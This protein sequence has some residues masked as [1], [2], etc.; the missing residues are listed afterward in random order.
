M[1]RPAALVALSLALSGLLA[2]AAFAA[3]LR[4]LQLLEAESG[5]RAVL[6]LDGLATPVRIFRDGFD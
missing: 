5:T 2:P 3:E 6:E 4:A 1:R